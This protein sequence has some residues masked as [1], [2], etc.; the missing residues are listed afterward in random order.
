[1]TKHT[2]RNNL[3][4]YALQFNQQQMQ[5]AVTKTL[6]V[7]GKAEYGYLISYEDKNGVVLAG[8]EPTKEE[9]EEM[10]V[11]LP[12]SLIESGGEDPPVRKRR[13]IRGRNRA[14]LDK[15]NE[16]TVLV[17]KI[18]DM[19]NNSTEYHGEYDLLY[20]GRDEVYYVRPVAEYVHSL[21]G[22]KAGKFLLSILNHP[23]LQECERGEYLIRSVMGCRYTGEGTGEDWWEEVTE[24][25]DRLSYLS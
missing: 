16:H 17:R 8:G 9:I 20:K 23:E 5:R 6:S 21:S 1:M 7:R 18:V 12:V 13:I 2:N 11:G 25:D 14:P 19:L 3:N 24:S 22:E 10:T 4:G 15:E